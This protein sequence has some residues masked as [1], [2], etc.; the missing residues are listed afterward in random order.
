MRCLFSTNAGGLLYTWGTGMHGQLGHGTLKTCLE[1]KVVQDLYDLSVACVDVS[2]GMYHNALI[3][4]DGECFTWGS[5]K[6]GCLG[7]PSEMAVVP[8]SYTPVP[9]LVE[10]LHQ[11]R[12]SSAGVVALARS[13]RRVDSTHRRFWIASLILSARAPPP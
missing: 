3:S 5:N 2:C 10:N 11:V 12:A 6:Y 8:A 4:A 9:G 7:R 13:L 1:P